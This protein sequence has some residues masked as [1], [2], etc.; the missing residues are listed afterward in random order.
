MH[1]LTKI[2]MLG[3]IAMLSVG[4]T[5]AY[6]SDSVSVI[7]HIQM[8]DINI[9]LR[10]YEMNQEGEEIPYKD[11]KMIVP[12]QTVSKIPRITN[13]AEPCYIRLLLT[14]NN[15]NGDLEG[16]SDKNVKGISSD[17]VKRGEYYYYTKVLG[18]N[19]TVDLFKKVTF[20]EEWTEA[21]SG[22]NI[23]INIQVD[24]IQS[25][26]FTPDFQSRNPWG[27][28]EIEVCVH[29]GGE[30]TVVSPYNTMFV[31][32]EGKS[33]K[34]LAVPDDFFSNIQT[35][36]PGDQLSDS[37]SLK[38]TTEQ[39]AEFF[40]H[41]ELPDSLTQEQYELMKKIGLKILLNGESIYQGDL[42]AASLKSNISL[43]K[44]GSGAEKEFSFQLD[45]PSELKNR[46]ALSDTLVKWVF[47]VK[48]DET[49]KNS[50]GG[51]GTTVISSPS[52]VKT[53][54]STQTA[55]YSLLLV[56]GICGLTFCYGRKHKK[57][58]EG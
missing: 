17:W 25:K 4:G 23:G 37:I 14:Y 5:W 31:E 50:P 52:P 55:A 54:D 35:A 15:D 30:E 57:D 8:G 16:L 18:Y 24:A 58:R 48:Q 36:M 32:F 26:N 43:G 13:I 49:E 1:K 20:P 28:E 40:F 27:N 53:G 2:A 34:L 6:F 19:Q 41:T 9:S 45:I 21:H 46:Y 51:T 12:G 3:I 33:H 47:S 56:S 39:E 44:Y 11:D 42:E 38:N 29:T 7:N 22:Q 10:E